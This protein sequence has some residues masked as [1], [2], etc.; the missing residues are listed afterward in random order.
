M[1]WKITSKALLV[2]SVVTGSCLAD[3]SSGQAQSYSKIVKM[4]EL[5]GKAKEKY[6]IY[7]R[8]SLAEQEALDDNKF[9]DAEIYRAEKDK[10]YIVY[11]HMMADVQVQKDAISEEAKRIQAEKDYR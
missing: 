2:L 9:S 6:D 4:K 5:E 11:Q 8:L 10:I 1:N 7:T 3:F